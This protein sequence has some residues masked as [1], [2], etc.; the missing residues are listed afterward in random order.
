[1]YGITETTVHA[2]Y[3]QIGAE[4]TRRTG[5]SLIGTAISDLQAFVVDRSL[6]LCPIGVAGEL[7]IGGAG[8]ARGYVN[9]PDL[10]AERFVPNPFGAAGSRMYRTGDLGRWQAEG[11]LEYLGR[12]DYQVKIRG[13]RIELGEIE[14][15]LGSYQGVREAVVVE[16]QGRL[17][18]YYTAAPG[19]EVEPG[20]LR[21]YLRER[22][23]DYMLPAA[24]V[25]LERMP[26]TDN[27][28]VDRKQLPEPEQG[29]E[30][31][32]PEMAARG[33]VEE[34]LAGIW[35]QLLGRERIGVHDNFFELGGH[36]LLA[37]QA[38]SRIRAVFGVEL[39][40]RA[41]FETADLAE[42]AERVEQQRRAGTEQQIPPLTVRERPG[43]VPLSFAQQRLWFLD[44]LGG[45]STEYNISQA[46]RLKGPLERRALE[47][48]I[49]TIVERHE[50]LRTHFE[51]VDGEPVQVIE[52]E[53]RIP[54]VEEDLSG[55][56]R[57]PHGSSV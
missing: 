57:K 3:L 7:Y 42:L 16:R 6:N 30:G 53:L 17:N 36:S 44:R 8:V 26:L 28:K 39:P 25:K 46:L 10:T 27:G 13:Y 31:G 55:R 41:L 24:V 1:M 38:I 29:S 14:A 19:A 22:L 54:V 32:P 4:S 40:L 23:P 18:G 34:L 11:N 56:R 9:R 37:T 47:R 49:R 2:T 45:G 48:T 5:R 15:V 33:P 52:A 50:S 21:G 51:E 20:Q 12:S 35:S 43:W